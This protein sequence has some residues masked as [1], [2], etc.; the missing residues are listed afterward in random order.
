MQYLSFAII[1]IV[2][3]FIY[4]IVKKENEKAVKSYSNDQFVMRLPK[5]YKWIGAIC[6]LFFLSLFI[7][8]SIFPNDTA[9]I[10]VG[11]GFIAFMALGLSLIVAQVRGQLCIFSDFFIYKTVFGREYRYK[12]GEVKSVKLTQNTLTIKT[13][14]KVFFVDAHALGVEVLL[15]KLDENQFLEEV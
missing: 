15:Q 5:T 11:V 2:T 14:N 6:A 10:W 7:L 4:L 8:M 12:F 9:E 3:S 13:H 1:P